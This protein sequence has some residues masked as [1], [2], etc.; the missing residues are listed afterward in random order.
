MGEP[1]TREAL[2]ARILNLCRETEKVCR[3]FE[4]TAA[5]FDTNGQVARAKRAAGRVRLAVRQAESRVS[6]QMVLAAG[7][8]EN[9]CPPP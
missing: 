4:E 6:G 8:R 7:V 1:L 5:A 9:P 3:D 2:A